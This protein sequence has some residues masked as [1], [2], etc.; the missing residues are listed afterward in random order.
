MNYYFSPFEFTI[1]SGIFPHNNITFNIKLKETYDYIVKCTFHKN[2]RLCL[3]TNIS[4]Q[5]IGFNY[6]I[7]NVEFYYFYYL[8]VQICNKC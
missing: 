2:I 3:R 1:K 5:I 7:I 8:L 6:K 4:F